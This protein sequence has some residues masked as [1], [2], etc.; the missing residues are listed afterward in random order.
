MNNASI[1]RQLFLVLLSA[2]ALGSALPTSAQ[3]VEDQMQVARSV[4][5][6]DR[7]AVVTEALHLT[8]PEA[9]AFWPLYHQYRAAMDEHGNALAKVILE[10]ANL[11]LDV[12]E[13][14]AS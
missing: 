6:A 9:Q 2:G 5:E 10:Y 14:R 3:T 7:H 12:P 13:V 8:D 11:Y 1:L 4:L